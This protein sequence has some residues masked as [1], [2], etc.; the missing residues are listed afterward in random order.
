MQHWLNWSPSMTGPITRP[1]ID[2]LHELGNRALSGSKKSSPTSARSRRLTVES[3][4][5]LFAMPQRLAV[6]CGVSTS[7]T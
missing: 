3:L 2:I 5:C 1:G 6:R 7:R 4:Y